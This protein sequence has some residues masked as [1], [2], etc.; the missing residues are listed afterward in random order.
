MTPDE[1]KAYEAG[2]RSALVA[3]LSDICRQLGYEDMAARQAAWVKERE[4]AVG[5]LRQLCEAFGDNDWPDDLHLYDILDK[6][7]GDHLHDSRS[8]A[9]DNRMD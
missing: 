3:M 7:L 1:E 4:A 5:V 8:Y 2:K 9:E 6:H